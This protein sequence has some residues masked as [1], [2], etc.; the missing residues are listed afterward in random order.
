MADEKKLIED[1]KNLAKNVDNS[2][3]ALT[4]LHGEVDKF[5][6]LLNKLK[7]NAILKS[8]ESKSEM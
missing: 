6:S 7:E 8:I 2:T 4:E 3:K 5:K 1:S